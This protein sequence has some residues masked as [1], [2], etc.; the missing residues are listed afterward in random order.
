MLVGGVASTLGSLTGNEKLSKIGSKLGLLGGATG[1]ASGAI[2]A[3]SGSTVLERAKA[4]MTTLSDAFGKGWDKI[5]GTVTMKAAPAEQTI[6]AGK[7]PQPET[8]N[9]QAAIKA[10]TGDQPKGLL[11]SLGL[12]GKDLMYMASGAAGALGTSD[13]D[14]MKDKTNLEREQWE[15]KQSNANS[16]VYLFDANNPAQVQEAQRRKALGQPV[17][18]VSNTNINPFN[19][20]RSPTYTPPRVGLLGAV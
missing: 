11:A 9:I 1:F 18:Q 6:S 7:A 4:G 10:K 20:G 14:A 5:T 19:T 2:N 8:G 15:T 17:Q 16:N 12:D 3:A 13:G